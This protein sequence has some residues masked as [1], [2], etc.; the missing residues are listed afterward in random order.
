MQLF[1]R[2]EI[3]KDFFGDDVYDIIGHLC[4]GH[5]G[6]LDAE[7][8][9]LFFLI[10]GAGIESDRDERFGIIRAFPQ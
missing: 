2:F 8:V 10:I 3:F 9:D 1:E 6:C 4:R 5:E 7:G